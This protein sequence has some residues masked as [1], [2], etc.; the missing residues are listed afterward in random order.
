MLLRRAVRMHILSDM[1]GM[2][3]LGL[4]RRNGDELRP[5]AHGFVG[6]NMAPNGPN[7]PNEAMRARAPFVAILSVQ[8]HPGRC[9]HV[10]EDM[11]AFS[12]AQQHEKA[13]VTNLYLCKIMH[14][15]RVSYITLHKYKFDTTASPCRGKTP[16]GRE[17]A[18]DG[19]H[20]STHDRGGPSDH[21][22]VRDAARRVE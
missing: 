8:S 16:R 22:L 3:G 1:S 4:N 9:G 21:G 14:A 11:H 12:T 15:S 20:R 5:G 7:G 13:V 10:G 17:G 6:A 18:K 2:P 19:C